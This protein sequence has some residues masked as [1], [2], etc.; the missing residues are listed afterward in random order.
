MNTDIPSLDSVP[1]NVRRRF[2]ILS[3]ILCLAIQLYTLILWQALVNEEH[4]NIRSTVRKEAEKFTLEFK[5]EITNGIVA[6][7]RMAARIKNHTALP[8]HTS[9]HVS[10]WILDAQ[11][12]LADFNTL[13]SIGQFD[14]KLNERWKVTKKS[15]A[16]Q[17]SMQAFLNREINL[18]NNNIKSTLI[19][20]ATWS[21]SRNLVV[22]IPLMM[23]DKTKD[24]L[25]ASFNLDDLISNI[26]FKFPVED[27]SIIFSNSMEVFN[28][29]RQFDDYSKSP[30]GAQEEI[31]FLGQKW[32]LYIWP[33]PVFLE[34]GKNILPGVVLFTGI[35]TNLLII[36]ILFLS[37][38]TWVGS[39]KILALN[40]TLELNVENR[41]KQLRL[42]KEEAERANR[43]K[44]EFLA[45]MSHELRT[46]MNAILGFTQL[47]EMDG[48]NL[49]ETQRDNIQKVIS[50]GNHLLELINE[51]LD[52]SKVES[53]NLKLTFELIDIVP[54]VDNVF[55]ISRPLANQ[56]GVSLEYERIPDENYFV[57]VDPL[58]MKQVVLNLVS[59]AIKY[60]KQGGSVVV[61]YEKPKANRIRLGIRDTGPGIPHEKQDRLFKPFE[62]LDI[63]QDQIEG[64]GIGLT[65]SKQL[66]N[67]MNGAIG[68]Q[69]APGR[70]SYFYIDFPLSANITQT[71]AKDKSLDA[72]EPASVKNSKKQILYIEDIPANV[73]LVR[74]ILLIK[75]NID[76]LW[77]GNAEDGILSAQKNIPDLILMDIHLPGMDG[78]TAFKQLQQIEAVKHIPVIALTA[79]AMNFEVNKVSDLGFHAYITKPIN[80]AAFLKI[81]DEIL[82]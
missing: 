18:A 40:Q 11:S 3:F 54:L 44:S 77:A 66:V 76:L 49:T 23:G 71:D 38:K 69:S 63:D 29:D 80:V 59:N 12:F 53:G 65:I 19:H 6:L 52:L 79:D 25:I 70:G 68:F 7:E 46:P 17:A 36:A 45:R 42:A 67:L 9:P 60:N 48:S 22:I 34:H 55:S 4:E 51:V 15:E 57:K 74:Q 1:K 8:G 58:R 21:N 27:F 24:Y 47:L 16:D 61:S 33:N 56:R 5:A 64:T 72:E 75:S 31:N 2:F 43:A 32:D 13:D 37:F 30:Y 81:I 73:E 28:N 35:L 50:A 26:L 14:Q 41:T 39:K 62:R 78:L 10:L 20:S 82:Q